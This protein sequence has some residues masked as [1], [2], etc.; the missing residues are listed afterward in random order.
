VEGKKNTACVAEVAVRLDFLACKSASFPALA[1]CSL[2]FLLYKLYTLLT[3]QPPC[4]MWHTLNW[5]EKGCLSDQRSL[6]FSSHPSFFFSFYKI[7]S[8]Y[9][10]AWNMVQVAMISSFILVAFTPGKP[11]S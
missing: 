2:T 10:H 11:G 8:S 7:C 3:W 1:V 6:L 5:L 4:V 9:V